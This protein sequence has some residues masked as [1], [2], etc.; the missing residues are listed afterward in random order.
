[1]SKLKIIFFNMLFEI[2]S[3][4]LLNVIT[5]LEKSG[6]P[7]K[8]VYLA[9]IE[10]ETE[11]ELNSILAFIESEKPDLIGFSLMTFNFF[12]TKRITIEIKKRMPDMPVIWGGIHPTFNP[13]ESI[14][15]ADY[16]C[17]GEGEDAVLEFVN[18]LQRG[19]PN[20]DIPNIWRKEKGT[21]V[22]N[23]VRPL[24]QNLDNYPFPEINWDRTY[25]L[26]EG[27]IKPLTHKRYRKCVNY[28]GTMYEIMISRG[29]LYA[30]SYCCNGLFKQIY[31]KKGKYVRYRSV[32]NVIEELEAAKKAFPFINMVNIQDDGFAAAPEDYLKEFADKYSRSIGLPLRLRIIPTF[33]NETKM[34]YLAKANTL[35]A[36]TGLQGNDRIN[37]E[38]FNRHTSAERFINVAKLLKK[39]NIIGQ[40]DLITQ[41]PYAIE[42][43][44]IEVCQTLSKLPK[45]YQ[46][47]MFP[48]A[49]FPNTPLREKAIADGLQVNE[50]DGYTM[51]YGNYP[52]RFSHLRK[53]Q[54]AC[55]YSPEFLINFAI[56]T[57]NSFAGRLF[58]DIY[59][60]LVF[61]SIHRFRHAIMQSTT[62]VQLTK[63]L[64]FLP[65]HIM[66]RLRNA[67][68]SIFK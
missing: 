36:V 40:Y 31:A 44:E 51:A 38:V 28:G 47:L 55:Q 29:C 12:R 18:A 30:C 3:L 27:A 49:F 54:A 61:E 65:N 14:K 37:R 16:V 62:L 52:E 22:K 41:N 10:D 9:K 1:M 45:P 53:I 6:Y 32:D 42:Q 39:Y 26:D 5:F 15:Y 23:D 13:E 11:E 35:V 59:Y 58:F 64:I 63:V 20:I 48:L 50:L 43:D 56:C 33:I 21:V 46:L 2:G 67:F 60:H 8:H 24:I 19:Q 34:Q 7:S 68:V 25:Y 4:G 66:S 17:V 57:R